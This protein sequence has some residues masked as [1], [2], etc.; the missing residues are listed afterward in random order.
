MSYR[1]FENAN[2]IQGRRWITSIQDM[3]SKNHFS[4]GKMS[5]LKFSRMNIII[6]GR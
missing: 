3:Q 5:D 6:L 1:S 4:S 2:L